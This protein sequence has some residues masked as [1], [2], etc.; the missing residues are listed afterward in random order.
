MTRRAVASSDEI[1]EEED[2]ELCS[3][4][5]ATAPQSAS[6]NPLASGVA[7]LRAAA[8]ERTRSLARSSSSGSAEA[9]LASAWRSWEASASSG[10][11]CGVEGAEEEEVEVVEVV[12]IDDA[13]DGRSTAAMAIGSREAL[14]PLL[15]AA[16]RQRG[17]DDG[18][19]RDARPVR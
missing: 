7:A 9:R 13:D 6:R 16:F 2:D 12:E 11:C 15:I 5:L 3:S 1:D 17:M 14:L 19:T 8:R 10:C 18:L 4:P